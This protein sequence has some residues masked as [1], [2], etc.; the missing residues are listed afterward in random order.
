M[1]GIILGFFAFSGSLKLNWKK[2]E[3]EKCTKAENRGHAVAWIKAC[4]G[5]W[6]TSFR[7]QRASCRGMRGIIQKPDSNMLRHRLPMPRNDQKIRSLPESSRLRHEFFMLRH[8]QGK[9]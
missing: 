3:D 1:Q 5:I 2:G 9:F 4:R 7:N 8:M 6:T